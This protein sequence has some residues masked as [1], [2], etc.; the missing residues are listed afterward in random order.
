VSHSSIDF[1]S[2]LSYNTNG[3]FFIAYTSFILTNSLLE[4]SQTAVIP[5]PIR[6][7]TLAKAWAYFYKRSFSGSG[8]LSAKRRTKPIQ[9]IFK[10]CYCQSTSRDSYTTSTTCIG[11]KQMQEPPMLVPPLFLQDCTGGALLH[12]MVAMTDDF[13]RRN[14]LIFM[15]KVRRSEVKEGLSDLNAIF[16]LSTVPFL[17]SKQ[18]TGSSSL[19]PLSSM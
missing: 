6:V 3:T 19:G 18:I 17:M 16:S 11:D 8:Q 9:I 14:C 1:K 10:P 4:P 15:K 12:Y 7:K 2:A 13:H 5:T